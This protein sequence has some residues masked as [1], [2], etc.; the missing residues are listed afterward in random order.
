VIDV[1][2]GLK[3]MTVLDGRFANVRPKRVASRAARN[4][5]VPHSPSASAE[6]A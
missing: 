1:E 2:H 3:L 4:I 5:A 6:S